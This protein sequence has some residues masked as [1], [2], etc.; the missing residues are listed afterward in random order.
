MTV[1]EQKINEAIEETMQPR[2]TGE[3]WKWAEEFMWL[4][5]KV[6][7]FPGYVN[8]KHSPYMIGKWSP[9]WAFKRYK[10]LSIIWG[11][12][13][14]KTFI[15]Q[16]CFA[17]TIKNQPVSIMVVYPSQI[18]ARRRSKKHLQS[19]IRDCLKEFMTGVDDDFAIFE[20]NLKNCS[21]ILSWA[22]S[23]A[24]LASEPIPFLILDEHAKYPAATEAEADA[25]SLAERRVIAAGEFGK[26]LKATTP[27]LE[28]E[29]GW[30]DLKNSTFCQNYVKCPECKHAQVMYFSDVDRNCIES[31]EDEWT[32]GI[33]WDRSKSITSR[34]ERLKTVYYQ[35]E[36]CPAQWNDEQVNAAVMEGEWRPRNPHAERYACHMPSWYAQWVKMKQVVGRWWDSYKNDG[37]RHD[38]LNSDCA[39]YYEVEAEKQT[40]IILKKHVLEGYTGDRIPNQ[41]V[42]LLLTADPMKSHI[43][44][45]IRAF[46]N[47]Y[48]SWGVEEGILMPEL[49]NIETLLL[50]KFKRDDGGDMFISFGL[51]DAGFRTDEVNQLC[52]RN[53]GILWASY[54]RNIRQDVQFPEKLVSPDPE[55]GFYEEGMITRIC[56]NADTWKNRFYTRLKIQPGGVGYWNLEEGLPDDYYYQ[57]CGEERQEK[58]DANGHVKLIWKQIHENHSFDC[59]YYM[60]IA[61]QVF[62]IAAMGYIPQGENVKEINTQSEPQINPYTNKPI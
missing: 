42:A 58:K 8:F 37:K 24:L 31:H 55:H 33:K 47:T 36:N 3:V 29:Y 41:A 6:T 50:K 46:S 2:F 18:I 21:I 15:L 1:I 54:G 10:E 32:G 22:G 12:Q 34:E 45:R 7:R 49:S 13:I 26:I 60:L 19:I 38:F 4:T 43:R 44:Y 52:F 56:Y 61:A 5:S 59:E 14:G 25:V 35:C 23:A 53:K 17:F 27:T 11:A 39:V 48:E 40:E 62:D 20:Y 57:M 30:S 9:L 16:V 51:V 28:H